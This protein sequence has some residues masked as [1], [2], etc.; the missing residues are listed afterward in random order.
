MHCEHAAEYASG[1]CSRLDR[2]HSLVCMQACWL[3]KVLL[4]KAVLNLIRST[5]QALA[6]RKVAASSVK[7]LQDPC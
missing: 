5:R 6:E 2:K 3:W 4:A 1:G 7:R